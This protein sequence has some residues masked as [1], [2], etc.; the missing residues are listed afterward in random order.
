M[1]AITVN[2]S[3]AS[4]FGDTRR[5]VTGMTRWADDVIASE[6]P[7]SLVFAQE[8][9]DDWLQLWRQAGYQVLLGDA[10]GQ[11]QY[12]VISALIAAPHLRLSP[13]SLS[14]IPT[15]GYHGS[16]VAAATWTPDGKD[17]LLVMSVHASPT[18]AEPY[19]TKWPE[20][21]PAPAARL[22][23]VQGRAL[24]ATW[25]ADALLATLRHHA[26]CGDLLAVGDLNEALGWDDLHPGDTSGSDYFAAVTDAGLVSVLHKRWGSER[27]T[28]R[29]LG[30]DG[31]QLD[32]ILATPRVADWIVRPEVDSDWATALDQDDWSDHAPVWF[33][34]TAPST[35]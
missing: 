33:T 18:R 21:V 32:H 22:T 34:V 30:E 29:V 25:D 23:G 10:V 31:L 1:R 20:D 2:V 13:V 12:K 8:C 4:P 28:R 16:Y 3:A 17:P 9:D 24:E 35:G 19:L 27:P 5:R 11:P 6:V 15:L 26:G 7:P 14:A